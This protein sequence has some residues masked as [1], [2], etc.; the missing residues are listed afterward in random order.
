ML[1]HQSYRPDFGTKQHLGI[2]IRLYFSTRVI[3]S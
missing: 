1:M 3:L 2:L